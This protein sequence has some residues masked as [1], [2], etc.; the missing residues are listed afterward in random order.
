M[1]LRLSALRKVRQ[2]VDEEEA[3]LVAAMKKRADDEKQS[4]RGRSFTVTRFWKSGNMDTTKWLEDTGQTIPEEYRRP[5]S[6]QIQVRE[7]KNK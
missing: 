1:E 6:Y 7:R 4:V 5:G 3:E 2:E